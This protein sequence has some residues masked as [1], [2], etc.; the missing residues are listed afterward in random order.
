MISVGPKRDDFYRVENIEFHSDPLEENDFHR[1]KKS[2][3]S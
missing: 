1:V 2:L 3:V